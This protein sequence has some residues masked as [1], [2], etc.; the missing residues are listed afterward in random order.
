MAQQYSSIL[1]RAAVVALAA[2]TLAGCG[3]NS[4]PT[5]EEQAKAKWA[6]VQAA[7]QERAN[8]VPNLRP[9]PKARLIRKKA[10]WWA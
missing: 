4:I 9:W 1:P 8:L 3:V 7:F 6:D 2:S 10:F 5:A